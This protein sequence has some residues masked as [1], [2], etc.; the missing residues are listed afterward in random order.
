MSTMV[1]FTPTARAMAA[2]LL[3]FALLVL[4]ATVAHADGYQSG[5]SGYSFLNWSGSGNTNNGYTGSSGQINRPH[6]SDWNQALREWREY[7]NYQQQQNN[8]RSTAACGFTGA[9]SYC[10]RLVTKPRYPA[11]YRVVRY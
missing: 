5:S 9:P 6:R 11:E 1:T 8:Q 2:L 10:Y 3:A 7:K 4:G